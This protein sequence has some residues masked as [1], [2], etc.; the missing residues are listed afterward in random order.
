MPVRI[1]ATA[2]PGN[3]NVNADVFL[4][5]DKKPALL[6]GAGLTVAR[7]ETASPLLL[8]DLRSDKNSTWVPQ[9]S[10]LTYVRID[11]PAR[12]L[13]YDLAIDAQ[14][15]TPRLADTG[16]SSAAALGASVPGLAVPGVPVSRWGGLARRRARVR[17]DL[18]RTHRADRNWTKSRTGASDTLITPLNG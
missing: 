4:L 14:G 7:S 5:T 15:H 11:T 12:N 6:H 9:Q 1:L 18:R 8:S 17:R 3:E 16:V 2:K 13:T 10:W